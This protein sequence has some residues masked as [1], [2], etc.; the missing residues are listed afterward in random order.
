MHRG[1]GLV[2]VQED[3]GVALVVFTVSRFDF[4]QNK[5]VSAVT[6]SLIDHARISSG[7]WSDDRCEKSRVAPY[8]VGAELSNE[9]PIKIGANGPPVEAAII[10]FSV[11]FIRF[12]LIPPFPSL[13]ISCSSVS[14]SLRLSFLRFSVSPSLVPSFLSL[15]VSRSFV[16][17]SSLSLKMKTSPFVVAA[18][19]YYSKLDSSRNIRPEFFDYVQ[20]SFGQ[21]WMS[22]SKENKE[23][24][25][26]K[27]ETIKQKG[28]KR[29]EH[30]WMWQEFL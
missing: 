17:Q 30:S 26:D 6:G 13:S 18:A 14:Q 28:L 29:I 8:L 7:Y 1:Q 25:K 20:K 19:Y 15:S 10:L 27:A 3:V 12:S 23:K 5:F 21:I 22:L 2:V 11:I 24:F 16:S 4:F 9:Q